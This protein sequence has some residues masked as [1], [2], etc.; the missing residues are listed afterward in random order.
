MTPSPVL[1]D[2]PSTAS[3]K[4]WAV[5]GAGKGGTEPPEGQE[6]RTQ[7]TAPW[8]AGPATHTVTQGKSLPPP[9]LSVPVPQKEDGPR[10]TW[11]I[12]T[13]RELLSAPHPPRSEPREQT[14]H[15]SGLFRTG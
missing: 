11:D 14:V 13:V 6:W 3:Q 15:S 7:L 12:Y 9:G 4:P 1:A 8:M 5:E 10:T 2:L